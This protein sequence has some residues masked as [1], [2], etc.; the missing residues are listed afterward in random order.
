MVTASGV[1]I[2][3]D[4]ILTNAHV[5][6]YV[7][8][9]DY[10]N[11]PNRSCVGRVGSPAK[12]LYSLKV[13]YEPPQWI[14]NNLTAISQNNPEGTG[15]YDYGLLEITGENKTVAPKI[16]TINTQDQTSLTQAKATAYPAGNSS[17]DQVLNNLNLI[18]ETGKVENIYSFNSDNSSDLISLAT[19]KRS[20]KRLIRRSN[21]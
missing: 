4:V 2:S 18:S 3:Q 6:Q 12:T 16:I 10:L 8:I 21:H 20:A 15:E 17:G 5:A 19:I 14:K 9:D 7:L 13:L 1:I 11:D